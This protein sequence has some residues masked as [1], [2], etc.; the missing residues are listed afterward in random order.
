MAI[1]LA[2][3]MTEAGG[4]VIRV[5]GHSGNSNFQT[6]LGNT[7]GSCFKIRCE[8]ESPHTVTEKW[9]QVLPLNQEAICHRY[10]L[11]KR[12]VFSNGVQAGTSATLPDRPY[13]AEF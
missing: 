13:A 2:T 11:G 1:T 8:R 6:G 12:L 7:V 5:K 10:L 9:T 4:L 3:R